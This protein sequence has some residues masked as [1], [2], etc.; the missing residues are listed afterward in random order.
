MKYNRY[1]F[2]E[3]RGDIESSPIKMFSY[4]DLLAML[5]EEPFHL[6][7]RNATLFLSSCF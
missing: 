1:T 6:S 4:Q 5:T 2:A 7:G 3:L